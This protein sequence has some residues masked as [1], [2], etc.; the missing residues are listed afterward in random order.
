MGLPYP[1]FQINYKVYPE[2]WG[3][4]GLA[5]AETIERAGEATDATFVVTPQVPDVRLLAEATELPITAPAIDPVSPGRG[6]GKLLPETLAKA[7]AAGAVINHAEN[8]ETLSG[9][10]RSIERC[11]SVGLDAIVCVD[12]VAMGR[13]VAAFEPD[14]LLF[15]RPDD[16]AGDQ[17]I[18]ESHPERIE[19]FLA[20]R[21][22]VA[23]ETKVRVGGGITTAEHVRKAFELGVD[24]AGAASAIATADEPATRLRAIGSVLA[25]LE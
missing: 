25:S 4:D 14:Q 17:P 19:Q 16:I 5:L 11:Q 10:E 1:H 8:R 7:G 6:M 18:V 12:S 21:E 20:M 24:A 15:E 22:A 2:T 3:T 9:I 23:P 13:A